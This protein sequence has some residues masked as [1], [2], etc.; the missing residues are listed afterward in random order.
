MFYFILFSNPQPALRPRFLLVYALEADEMVQDVQ[1]G[2]EDR[3]THCAHK[4]EGTH[5]RS[6]VPL[7]L[8]VRL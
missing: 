1:P 7:R 6:S 8:R 3:I 2:F 5:E 4:P